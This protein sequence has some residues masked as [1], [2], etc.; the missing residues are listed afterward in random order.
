MKSLSVHSL[1]DLYGINRST[2]MVLDRNT[3]I[4]RNTCMVLGNNTSI[5]KSWPAGLLFLLFGFSCFAYVEWRTVLL[6]WS[7]QKQPN[8][9]S[10]IQQYFPLWWVVSGVGNRRIY[11]SCASIIKWLLVCRHFVN[12]TSR[13]TD[14]CSVYLNF[15]S[16]CLI[17][18]FSWRKQADIVKRSNECRLSFKSQFRLLFITQKY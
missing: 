8:R 3:S 4:G 11:S 2:W 12:M 18:H 17:F 7:N 1:E 15:A 13:C 10:A 9:R 6:V 14:E 5:G 16:T